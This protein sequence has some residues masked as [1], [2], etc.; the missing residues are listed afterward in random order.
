MDQHMGA[1]PPAHPKKLDPWEF[2]REV[3]RDPVA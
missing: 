1:R 2:K 3:Y